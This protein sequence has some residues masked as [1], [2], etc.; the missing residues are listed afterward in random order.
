MILDS[1]ISQIQKILYEFY[2]NNKKADL[3]KD[4]RTVFQGPKKS[5]ISINFI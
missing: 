3:E 5:K 4:R 1:V 2:S